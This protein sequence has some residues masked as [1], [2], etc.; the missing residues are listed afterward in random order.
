MA[1]IFRDCQNELPYPSNTSGKYLAPREILAKSKKASLSK[2]AEA[3]IRS[4][5]QYDYHAWGFSDILMQ[6]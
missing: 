5:S 1:L 3:E 6:V 2:S 4:L